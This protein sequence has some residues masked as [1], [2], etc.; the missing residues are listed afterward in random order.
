M[1][2]KILRRRPCFPWFSLMV[3]LVY[4]SFGIT[5]P[6]NSQLL[7]NIGQTFGVYPTNDTAED[8]RLIQFFTYFVALPFIEA[9]FGLPLAVMLLLVGFLNANS[10]P[11][12]PSPYKPRCCGSWLYWPIITG[13]LLCSGYVF[14]N[15]LVGPIAA[16]VFAVAIALG[17]AAYDSTFS[18]HTPMAMA[19]GI[20]ASAFLLSR[21][22]KSAFLLLM[23]T[24]LFYLKGLADS[25]RCQAAPPDALQN[26]E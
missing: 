18:W 6:K 17:T 24:T 5:Q 3:L 11:K 9:F 4:V 15:A 26:L 13:F 7:L 20:A 19:G 10:P 12:C 25:G 16:S 1:F 8:A 23:I 2:E 21:G 22:E 14:K